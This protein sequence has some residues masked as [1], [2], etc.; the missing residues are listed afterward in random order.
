MHSPLRHACACAADQMTSSL[1]SKDGKSGGSRVFPQR[2]GNPSILAQFIHKGKDPAPASEPRRCVLYRRRLWPGPQSPPTRHDARHGRGR[3]SRRGGIRSIHA[4]WEG[5]G[6]G[7]GGGGRGGEGGGPQT[8]LIRWLECLQPGCNRQ[9]RNRQNCAVR[10]AA[11]IG[12]LWHRQPPGIL[13]DLG[14]SGKPSATGSGVVAHAKA[15]R[16]LSV[17]GAVSG[18]CG[19]GGGFGRGTGRT[20]VRRD[21]R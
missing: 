2:M 14:L 15:T 16:R 6:R 17:R 5:G 18:V 3:M 21:G 1:V 10:C 4:A 7:E 8:D 19:R 20:C 12:D 9:C 11:G 13:R